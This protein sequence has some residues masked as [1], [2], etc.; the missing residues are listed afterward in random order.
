MN[1]KLVQIAVTTVVMLLSSRLAW[2]QEDEIYDFDGVADMDP[3]PDD[4]TDWMTS[5]NWSDGG[6]DPHPSFGPLIPDFGT[7]VHIRTST[8]GVNA[9]EIGPGDMAQA[10]E[11]RIGRF[12]GEGLL[13]MT[14]G[15]LETVNSCTVTPFVCNRRLRVGAADTAFLEDRHP[16]TFNLIDGQVTTD[17][18]WIGSGSH[19]EMNLSDG[20]VTTRENLYFDWTFDAGS[21]L[22]MSGGTINVGGVLRMYRT[23]ELNLD[24]GQILVAGPAELGTQTQLNPDF[25]QTPDITATIT[26]GLLASNNFLQIGGAVI[27]DGGIL[28]A[29]SFNESVSAG[30]IEVNEGGTLQFNNAQESVANVQNLITSGFITTSS[31]LGT[32]GFVIEVVDVGGT[33]FTQVAFPAGIAGDYNNDGKVDA[34][35]YVVWRKTG[36][37][38]QQ[39]YNVWRANFGQPG[40]GSALTP[41]A[42][43]EP[44][45]L[46]LVALV[47][48]LRLIARRTRQL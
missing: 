30:T 23:S 40:A 20:V 39:G 43:P 9:P 25:L 36:I 13:T 41:A 7:R 35:D 21:T 32:A 19:G 34:A 46:A 24:G 15:T 16:G 28:R 47:L 33:N 31:P 2:A 29:A 11:V 22:N 26:D 12:Q 10:F 44:A 14:G 8:F 42:V 4:P 37:D 3:Q 5:V 48:P 38:G 1:R 17:N 27:V 45:T 6:F 18:L